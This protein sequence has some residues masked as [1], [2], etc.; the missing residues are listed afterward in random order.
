MLKTTTLLAA[1]LT[2][3]LSTSVT[4]HPDRGSD[5]NQRVFKQKM[6]K[7]HE[8]GMRGMDGLR[9][10]FAHLDLS[11]EQKASLKSLK[12]NNKETMTAVRESILPLKKQMHELMSADDL[13]EAA[14]RDLSARIADKKTDQMILMASIK[15]QAIAILTDEQ[16]AEL[17]QMKEKRMQKRKQRR[18]HD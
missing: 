17:K 9:R 1:V 8:R 11:E 10:A 6:H 18:S 7:Q 4:A 3:T 15:K 5:K 16:K 2:M 13:D 14:I 12:Q